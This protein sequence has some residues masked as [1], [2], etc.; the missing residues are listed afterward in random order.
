MMARMKLRATS[1]GAVLAVGLVTP[2]PAQTPTQGRS[3]NTILARVET[4]CQA[5][6]V[7]FCAG[8]PDTGGRSM[9]IC[10]KYYRADLTFGCRSAVAA[11]ERH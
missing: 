1:L 3:A 10:L 9:A 2:L 7:K 4:S 11:A 6:F 5:D 8:P